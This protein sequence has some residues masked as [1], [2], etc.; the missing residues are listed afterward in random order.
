MNKIDIG[1]YIHQKEGFKAFIP[2][3]F[4][5]KGDFVLDNSLMAKHTEAI[6]LLG[7]L[8]GITELLPDKDWFLTMFIRKD[9]SSSS[10]IEGTNA[11]MMDA[12]ERENV[13]PSTNLPAD[14]DDIIHYIDALNYGLKRAR[15]FPFTLR[16]VRELHQQLM[17]NARVTH[18]AYP[19]EFRTKQNWISGTR[20][21][22]AKYV[23]PPV[24]EMNQ[25]LDQLEKFVH[26]EDS[27]LPLVKAG[28]LHAQFETIHPFNDGNGRTG[29]MLITMFLWYNGL[30]EMPILYLSSYFK[31]HQNL[32]Y[33]RLDGYHNGEVMEWLD[34]FLDGIIETANSA[35]AT[36]A[37]I[38]KL[39]ERD[40]TK[41]QMLNRTASEATVKVLEN[42]Y[43]MPIAGIADIV[44]W[45]GYT[46]RGCYNVID[47]LVVMEVLFPMK[48]GD[49]VYAQKWV[50][51]DYLTLFEANN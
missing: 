10:Q 7:K 18:P 36:C 13:E 38:T 4:P 20:P 49:N 32:Y 2:N 23:P 44:K 11:T 31:Q 33:E 12:I 48:A 35:I 28:F 1:Q 19:G 37:A 25:A 14:V 21:D 22:N 51:R 9:A 41:V 26:A 40:M 5:P 29:R 34:F 8:D 17:T 47:R 30:L 6:R 50:Y 42:L 16:F 46:E 43:R 24:H 45:T 27:Y 3:D 15:S 39:R